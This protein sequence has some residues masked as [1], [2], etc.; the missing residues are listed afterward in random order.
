MGM[1][2][3]PSDI[4]EQFT[5][6][7]GQSVWGGSLAAAGNFSLLTRVCR[8]STGLEELIAGLVNAGLVSA[9]EMISLFAGHSPRLVRA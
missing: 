7:L 6:H 9:A 1:F 3:S 2:K 4:L 8:E 5:F